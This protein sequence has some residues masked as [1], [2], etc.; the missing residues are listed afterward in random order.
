EILKNIFIHCLP[1]DPL[2][3]RQPSSTTAPILL[4]HI[5]SSWRQ[6]P[7]ASATLW[8]HLSKCF[9]HCST[10]IPLLWPRLRMDI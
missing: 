9:P 5:C 8:T 4:C 1:R 10:A 3:Q 6:L 7:Q 2:L